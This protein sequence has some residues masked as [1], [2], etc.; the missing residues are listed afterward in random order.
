MSRTLEP[1]NQTK[2]IDITNISVYVCVF[3]DTLPAHLDWI[4]PYS[5][6]SLAIP[7][8]SVLPASKVQKCIDWSIT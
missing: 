5:D 3:G 8:H 4:V 2:I 1:F 6:S 7:S